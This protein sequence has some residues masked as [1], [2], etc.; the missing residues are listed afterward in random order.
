MTQ[1]QMVS[2]FGFWGFMEGHMSTKDLQYSLFGDTKMIHLEKDSFQ[3]WNGQS[4]HAMAQ[5]IRRSF[6]KHGALDGP[7]L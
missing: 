2:W 6:A 4:N 7:L 1:Q 5:P 3:R